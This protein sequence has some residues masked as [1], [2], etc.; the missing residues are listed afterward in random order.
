MDRT[1]TWK[2]LWLREIA[3]ITQIVANL[4]PYYS[5]AIERPLQS[6]KTG[7][8]ELAQTPPMRQLSEDF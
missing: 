6:L 8:K 7:P 1:F 4:L 2:S 5:K 3:I